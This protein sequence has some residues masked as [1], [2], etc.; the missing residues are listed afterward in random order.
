MWAESPAS[1]HG[2][3]TSASATRP[4]ANPTENYAPKAWEHRRSTSTVGHDSALRTQKRMG[5]LPR[6]GPLG[7]TWRV[8]GEGDDSL[9]RCRNWRRGGVGRR[10]LISQARATASWRLFEW[11]AERIALKL[12]GAATGRRKSAVVSCQSVPQGNEKPCAP[13]SLKCL[14]GGRNSNEMCGRSTRS[15][16]WQRN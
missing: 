10:F 5:L 1:Q 14:F 16:T 13:V 11:A 6:G 7:G 9:T 2:D 3:G 8:V 4:E 12:Q 15:S